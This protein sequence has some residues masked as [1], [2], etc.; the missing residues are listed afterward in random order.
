MSSRGKDYESFSLDQYSYYNMLYNNALNFRFFIS[1]Q[2]FLNTVISLFT[3]L[4]TKNNKQL[5]YY[6][7]YLSAK[8]IAINTINMD[9]F[10][11]CF[12]KVIQPITKFK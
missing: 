11:S 1:E 5:N 12:F 7:A 9:A 4:N 3:I 6:I 8:N 2:N 10:P